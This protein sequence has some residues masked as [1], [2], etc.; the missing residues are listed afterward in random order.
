[1]WIK[2]IEI[3]LT[4]AFYWQMKA[5]QELQVQEIDEAN[6]S[7]AFA[8]EYMQK[9]ALCNIHRYYNDNETNDIT[10]WDELLKRAAKNAKK[11]IDEEGLDA[12]N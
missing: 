9:V 6:Q 2:Q 7:M 10:G 1:M 8:A 5:T 12:C 11:R 3:Q 4:E